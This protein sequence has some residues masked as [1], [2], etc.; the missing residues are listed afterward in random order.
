MAPDPTDRENHIDSDDESGANM[1]IE[2]QLPN[3]ADGHAGITL[4]RFEVIPSATV[5]S[6]GVS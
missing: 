1:V 2:K 5:T 4:L 6:T 3:A